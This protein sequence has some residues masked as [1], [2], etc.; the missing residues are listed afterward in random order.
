MDYV[1]LCETEQ[2][3]YKTMDFY[4]GNFLIGFSSIL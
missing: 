1:A 3:C 2:S 4:V